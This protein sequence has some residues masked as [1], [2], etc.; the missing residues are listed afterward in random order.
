[1]TKLVSWLSALIDYMIMLLHVLLN[2]HN[3]RGVLASYIKYIGS[4]SGNGCYLVAASVP[5]ILYCNDFNNW[6]D[7]DLD[8]N[9][10]L[11]KCFYCHLGIFGSNF[12][13]V[14]SVNI[15]LLGIFF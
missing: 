13:A 4:H 15:L 10:A 7:R 2:K 3:L 8:P 6:L 14:L 1:M 12:H 5:F 9:S 11:K